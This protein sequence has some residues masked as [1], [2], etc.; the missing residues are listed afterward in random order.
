MEINNQTPSVSATQPIQLV[1]HKKQSLIALAAFV[2][3]SVAVLVAYYSDHQ[4]STFSSES[5]Q[6]IPQELSE[7]QI[8]NSTTAQVATTSTAQQASSNTSEATEGWLTFT[9]KKYGYSFNH[10]QISF[11]ESNEFTTD[12]NEAFSVYWSG[13]KTNFNVEVQGYSGD[14]AAIKVTKLPLK[15]FVQEIWR[16]NKE[17]INPNGVNKEVGQI[18]QTTIGGKVVYQFTLTGE[19]HT[20]NAS[21]SLSKKYRYLFMENN[22]LKFMVWLPEEDVTAKTI[23]ESFKFINQ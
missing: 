15:E 12:E 13:N 4:S 6:S 5:K 11:V 21:Y 2:F 8:S 17:Y 22:G 3:I 23:L 10:P 7:V 14:P 19:F 18:S 20:E 9:N 16:E 1:N